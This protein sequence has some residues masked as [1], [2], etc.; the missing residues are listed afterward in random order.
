MRADI[1]LG[2]GSAAVLARR[3]G[4]VV[5][6]PGPPA[7]FDFVTYGGNQVTRGGEPVIARTEI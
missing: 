5:P 7:G 3:G 1:G 4:S 2:V 6:P